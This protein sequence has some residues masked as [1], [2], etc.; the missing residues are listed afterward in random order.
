MIL[1]ENKIGILQTNSEDIKSIIKRLDMY[2]SFYV[3]VENEESYNALMLI[4]ETSNIKWASGSKATS[5]RRNYS[6]FKN[7][8]ERYCVFAEYSNID[9]KYTLWATVRQNKSYH[10]D[11]L[12]HFNEGG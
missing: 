6:W 9:K 11:R 4:F 7:K 12:I 3:S 8:A 10:S 5:L 2:E 1:I